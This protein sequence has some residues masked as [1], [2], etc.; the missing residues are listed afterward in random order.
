M[1]PLIFNAVART[2]NSLK[3]IS[4]I[5]DGMQLNIQQLCIHTQNYPTSVI[6]VQ[7]YKP[8]PSSKL[9]SSPLY[10]HTIFIQIE[11]RAFISYK[12]LLTSHLYEPLLHFTWMLIFFRVLNPSIYLNLGIY[13]NPASI[14]INT[15]HAC[16]DGSLAEQLYTSITDSC[17]S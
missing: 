7:A 13:L 6:I 12:W 2:A 14:W 8:M 1:Q 11:A 9:M 16:M 17:N 5:S 10:S 15:V 4:K 3:K